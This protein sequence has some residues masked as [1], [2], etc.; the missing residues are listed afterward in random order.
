MG[1]G[2]HR[3]GHRQSAAAVTHNDARYQQVPRC[4]RIC[5]CSVGGGSGGGRSALGVVASH[6]GCNLVLVGHGHAPVPAPP[7]AVLVETPS[8]CK[9]E[10]WCTCGTPVAP[11]S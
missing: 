6:V 9:W 10:P 1:F 5:C 11:V 4:Y 7:L 8:A 3:A 2:Q